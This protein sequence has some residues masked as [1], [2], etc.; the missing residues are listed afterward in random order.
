MRVADHARENETIE[1]AQ[2]RLAEWAGWTRNMEGVRLG[3]PT[4][5]AFLSEHIGNVDAPVD[6]GGNERAEEIENVMCRMREVRPS[7]HAVLM[8]AYLLSW[9]AEST[10]KKLGIG[11]QLYFD[12]KRQGEM[13]I[14]GRLL[15]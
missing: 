7:L 3:Y 6:D 15:G 4:H 13:F 2:A 10:M 1:Y 5:S 11:R 8:H 14:A 12:R 9:P